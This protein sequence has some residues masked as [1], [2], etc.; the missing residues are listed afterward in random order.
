MAHIHSI[1]K[2]FGYEIRYL[3]YFGN[4]EFEWLDDPCDSY[5]LKYE[6]DQLDEAA[7]DIA[8]HGG[9]LVSFPHRG[10]DAPVSAAFLPSPAASLER[11]FSTQAAE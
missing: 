9:E 11:C 1:E 3:A 7:D 8:A 10:T 5:V 2:L 6:D 4:G